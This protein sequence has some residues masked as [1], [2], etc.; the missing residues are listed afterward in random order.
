MGVMQ[1]EN[2]VAMTNL[3][4]KAVD[5]LHVKLGEPA[6]EDRNYLVGLCIIYSCGFLVMM[7]AA[8]AW[9]GILIGLMTWTS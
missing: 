1:N 7:L 6:L 8:L 9:A 4:N 5:W 3:L 2:S